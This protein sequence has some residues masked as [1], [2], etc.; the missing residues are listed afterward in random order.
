MINNK[1]QDTLFM[2]EAV[3]VLCLPPA[4]INPAQMEMDRRGYH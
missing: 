3:K 2:N 4:V 1:S